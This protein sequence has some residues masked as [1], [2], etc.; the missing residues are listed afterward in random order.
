MGGQVIQNGDLAKYDQQINEP[1]TVKFSQ[2]NAEGQKFSV[3]SVL[4]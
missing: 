4:W 2:L 1:L 3:A